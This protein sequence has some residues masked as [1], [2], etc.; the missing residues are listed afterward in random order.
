VAT[1][2]VATPVSG[3]GG[4]VY[5]T[6]IEP[7]NLDI[8]HV[9][10]TLPRLD[11]QFDGFRLAQLSDFHMGSWM[12]GKRLTDIIRI[13]NDEA[14]DM[15][16]L[17]GDYFTGTSPDRR[18]R[19]NDEESF[20]ST[21]TNIFAEDVEMACS[22]IQAPTVGILGNHDHRGWPALVREIF[23][24]TGVID[25]S[26]TVYTLERDGAFL[27][28]GGVDD[29]KMGRDRLDVVLDQ[30][31]SDGAAILLAHEPDFADATVRT[32]R[33]DLQISGHSH[34]GQVILPFV[35]PLVLPELGQKY[36]IGLYELDGMYQYTNRGIGM[37]EPAVRFNCRPELTIFTFESPHA[38]KSAI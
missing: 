19:H 6:N 7:T 24:R 27:Q 38:S 2:A 9:T 34:G 15:V 37:S 25:L 16:A 10:L 33:F 28:F 17:T 22:L 36:P 1:A 4:Y 26:N 21:R 35:G 31:P 13:V 29:I 20:N 12:T 11:P 14:P 8:N 5:S 3:V 32:G 23:A 30:L 18:G